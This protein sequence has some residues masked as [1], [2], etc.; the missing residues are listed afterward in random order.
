VVAAVD[1]KF[2]NFVVV[3]VVDYINMNYVLKILM[4]YGGLEA[5]V[6]LYLKHNLDFW[7][8]LVK[9]F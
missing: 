3:V 8:S 7:L 2:D 1:Y 9:I 5:L 4:S 6:Y